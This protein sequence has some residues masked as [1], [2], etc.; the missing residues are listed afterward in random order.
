MTS[1]KGQKIM[2]SKLQKH[3]PQINKMD[4]IILVFLHQ[5]FRL[6]LQTPW[7]LRG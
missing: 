6:I 2:Q 5:P 1:W 3:N 4:K 7:Q